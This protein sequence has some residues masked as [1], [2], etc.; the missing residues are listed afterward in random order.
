VAPDAC[1]LTVEAVGD[2]ITEASSWRQKLKNLQFMT[3]A[4]GEP[5]AANLTFVGPRYSYGTWHGAYSDYT[6]AAVVHGCP[7][8]YS[9]PCSYNAGGVEEWLWPYSDVHVYLVH[10][11]TNN[12][13]NQANYLSVNDLKELLDAIIIHQSSAY[14][15]LSN[16]IPLDTN[17]HP[18]VT[19]YNNAIVTVV[20]EYQA[21][22]HSVF[23]VDNNSGFDVDKDTYDKIHPNEQGDAKMAQKFG[24]AIKDHVC[25]KAPSVTGQSTDAGNLAPLPEPVRIY[26][27]DSKACPQILESSHHT[28]G[29]P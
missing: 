14:I 11:G 3:S 27:T 9:K 6:T 12:V 5:S 13:W 4:S 15:L 26:T 7:G 24:Q 21:L 25:C 8:Q 17:A 19:L 23:L 1:T 2:S 20:A 22:G 18:A 28:C 29:A 16:L 10:I